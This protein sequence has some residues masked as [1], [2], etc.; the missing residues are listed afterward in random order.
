MCRVP[1]V[2]PP[3]RPRGRFLGP[4]HGRSDRRRALW[5]SIRP[6]AFRRSFLLSGNYELTGVRADFRH[7][8]QRTDLPAGAQ[9]VV[10]SASLPSSWVAGTCGELF[11]LRGVLPA[12]TRFLRGAWAAEAKPGPPNRRGRWR[13][14]GVLRGFFCNLSTPWRG[15]DLRQRGSHLP[16]DVGDVCERLVPGALV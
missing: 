12:A 6:C 5:S 16:E 15:A 10:A 3:T 7:S 14:V 8:V 4:P 9:S 1:D 11:G 2:T 13:R